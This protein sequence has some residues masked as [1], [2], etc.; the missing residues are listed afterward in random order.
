[1]P[2]IIDKP[3]TQ[4]EYND[5]LTTRLG[6]LTEK[7]G[8]SEFL[9]DLVDCLYDSGHLGE[10]L[11]KVEALHPTPVMTANDK[12]TAAY[13]TGWDECSESY[14]EQYGVAPLHKDVRNEGSGM[15]RVGLSD[16]DDEFTGSDG[17]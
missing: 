4:S 6:R 16:E 10:I 9:E 8:T 11:D 5:D 12:L 3:L 7:L 15:F 13:L 1:M 2:P 17:K 14:V